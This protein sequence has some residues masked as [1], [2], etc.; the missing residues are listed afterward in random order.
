MIYVRYQ[1]FCDGPCDMGL[2]GDGN[3]RAAIREARKAGWV[4]GPNG[5]HCPL[6]A[7]DNRRAARAQRGKRSKQAEG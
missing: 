7:A 2:E 3:S 4:M 1:I 6:C 5:H